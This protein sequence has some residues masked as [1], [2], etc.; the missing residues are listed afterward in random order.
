MPSL[1][2]T[3]P[4]VTGSSPAPVCFIP[5]GLVAQLKLTTKQN[6]QAALLDDASHSSPP[7][8]PQPEQTLCTTSREVLEALDAAL[9]APLTQRLQDAINSVSRSATPDFSS[10][11]VVHPPTITPISAEST[12]VNINDSDSI[13]ESSANSQEPIPPPPP[14]SSKGPFPWK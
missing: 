12:P 3:P 2:Q 5:G 4:V 7:P 1:T 8:P 10:A 9:D 13:T 11:T 14:V 6:V